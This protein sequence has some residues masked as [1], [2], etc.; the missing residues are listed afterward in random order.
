[1]EMDKLIDLVVK[2]VEEKL[3]EELPEK[4]LPKVLFI[5]RDEHKQC[6]TFLRGDTFNN[7]CIIEFAHANDSVR[8]DDYEEIIVKDLDCENL[9]KLTAGI[10][11]NQ[12]LKHI[13]DCILRG[14]R[15]TVVIDDLDTF[16][17]RKTAPKAFLDMFEGKLAILRT[18]G[19]ELSYADQIIDRLSGKKEG[20][21]GFVLD[22]KVITASDVMKAYSA[23][24][25]TIT[26]GD[27][28]IITDIAKEYIEKNGIKLILKKV[29]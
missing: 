24:Y 15:I 4:N 9:S 26:V 14:K 11:D 13:S 10:F 25:L 19:I 1:M 29:G 6:Q 3:A 2:A 20:S 27:N 8:F 23:G 17:Y 5:T 16:K 28:A 21:L 12:Y 18:W 22:K 7:K